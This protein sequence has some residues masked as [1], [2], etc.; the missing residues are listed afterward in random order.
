MTE[1][2]HPNDPETIRSLRTTAGGALIKVDRLT[3]TLK[4]IRTEVTAGWPMCDC[5]HQA[6]CSRCEVDFL[7]HQVIDCV[8]CG[9]DPCNCEEQAEA[10]REEAEG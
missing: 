6:A 3:D 10:E 4:R 1:D 2:H 8:D 5:G 9:H 7:L